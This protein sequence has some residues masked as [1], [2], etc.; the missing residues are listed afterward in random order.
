MKQI[1]AVSGLIILAVVSGCRKEEAPTVFEY[2]LV[3]AHKYAMTE[4][5]PMDQV[6]EDTQ[7]ALKRLFGTPDEPKLPEV[8]SEDEELATLVSLD[9]LQRA[10]GPV[11]AAGE[12]ADRGLYRKHC[13]SCHGVTGNGRGL[14]GALLNPYPRDYRMGIFKF[15]STTRG[16]KPTRDDLAELIR[17]G[18]PG[19]AMVAIPE[20]TEED[21]QALVDYVIYLSWR[22]E[23]ER[24]MIDVAVMDLLETERLIDPAM[25]DSQDEKEREQFEEEWEYITDDVTEIGASWLEAEDEVTE[26]ELPD[27]L[28]L[29]RDREEFLAMMAGPQA[30]ALEASVVRGREIFVGSVASCSKCHGPEGKGDGQ[31]DDFDDWTKDWT[32]RVGLDPTNREQL[33]PLLARGALLPQ[34][35]Q[36][37]N[38]AEG[39]FRGGSAPEDLYRRIV[40]GIDGTPMPGATFVE[41]QFEQRDVWHVINFIRSLQRDDPATEPTQSETAL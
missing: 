31:T 17:H 23:L 24:R 25:A 34:N 1:F 5:R 33:I 38:F 10:A 30:D 15:K 14:T 41:G 36:P 22:G 37:R 13:A 4:D 18:I 19:T 20:L 3:H 16:A 9:R 7:W 21:V 39:V 2:N 12:A 29:P 27:D 11:P 26:V 6:V 35:V 32:V 8:V 40:N 28:P